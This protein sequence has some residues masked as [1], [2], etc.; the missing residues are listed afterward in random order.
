V[1]F[2]S[3]HVGSHPYAGPVKTQT[4]FKSY[5]FILNSSSV[6]KFLKEIESDSTFA[7]SM[8][9]KDDGKKWEEVLFQRQSFSSDWSEYHL[10]LRVGL[11]YQ[12]LTPNCRYSYFFLEFDLEQDDFAVPL[13]G[14]LNFKAMTKE[15]IKSYSTVISAYVGNF[16]LR[17]QKHGSPESR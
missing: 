17:E 4:V 7:V 16:L 12:K 13:C 11:K 15:Q 5:C 3:L 8:K 2:F 9:R 14:I 6:A 10:L 1:P